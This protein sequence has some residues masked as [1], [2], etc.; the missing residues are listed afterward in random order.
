M[1]DKAKRII[2]KPISPIREVMN[3]HAI[4]TVEQLTEEEVIEALNEQGIDSLEKLV[5][6]SLENVRN[7]SLKVRPGDIA[8]D[9]FVFTQYIFKTEGP[10]LPV[11]VIRDFEARLRQINR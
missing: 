3:T 10:D 5:S 8:K 6:K 1:S 9:T 7:G 2:G 4:E 11:E